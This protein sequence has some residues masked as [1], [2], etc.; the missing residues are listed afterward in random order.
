MSVVLIADFVDLAIVT[1]VVVT[2]AGVAIDLG[3]MGIVEVTAVN[4]R[5]ECFGN[6]GIG[7]KNVLD[8]FAAETE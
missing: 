1:V 7:G 8:M 4:G 2:L 3:L 5:G 6:F